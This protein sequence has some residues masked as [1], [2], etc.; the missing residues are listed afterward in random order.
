MPNGKCRSQ[1]INSAV[2]G[3]DDGLRVNKSRTKELHLRHSL[4]IIRSI[5]DICTELVL[6]QLIKPFHSVNIT[7]VE[8][9]PEQM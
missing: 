8:D 1:P 6:D 2:S 7:P 4:I 3:V 9:V 5:L